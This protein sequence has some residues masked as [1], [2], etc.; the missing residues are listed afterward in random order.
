M[1]APVAT[2]A[3]DPD[4]EPKEGDKEPDKKDVKEEEPKIA[5]KPPVPKEVIEDVHLT[6]PSPELTNLLPNDTEHIFHGFFK[7]V[8]D[9]LSPFR[10]P[11][12]GDSRAL[13]DAAF[14]PRLGFA[15]A[16]IDDLGE[17]RAGAE[18][19]GGWRLSG[20]LAYRNTSPSSSRTWSTMRLRRRSSAT[21]SS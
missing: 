8:F 16:E 17:V 18:R 4:D 3:P 13:T 11:I 15:V 6:P 7:E 12:A 5:E 21:T 9:V 20:H 1:A 19:A 10:G 2:S 14:K